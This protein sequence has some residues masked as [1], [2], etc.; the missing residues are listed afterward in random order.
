MNQPKR[1]FDLPYRQL[2]L[3][4]N[5][6]MLNTKVDGQWKAISSSQFIDMVNEVSRGLIAVGVKPGEKVGLIS[7]NRLEW[8]VIDFAIQQVGGVVVAIYPNISDSDYEYIFKD[9]N[10][11]VCFVSNDNLYD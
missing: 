1:L 2:E 3:F 8:N 6:N 4:P 11:K 5:L 10:I 9:A 7:E